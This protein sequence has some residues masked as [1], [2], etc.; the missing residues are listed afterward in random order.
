[1][2][3]AGVHR[4][5]LNDLPLLL[6][7]QAAT[8]PD[9]LSARL[10]T[11]FNALFHRSMLEEE[12]YLCFGYFV[13]GSPVGYLSC[14]SNTQQLLRSAFRRKMPQFITTLTRELLSNMRLWRLAARIAYSVATGR[15]EPASAVHAEFLSI[16]VLP[17]FRGRRDGTTGAHVSV[18][19]LLLERAL[20]ALGERGVRAVKACVT[21]DNAV[22]NGFYKKNAFVFQNRI[23][24]F[25]LAAYLYVRALDPA[26]GRP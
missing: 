6:E 16:G 9:T 23:H 22:A 15:G 2:T 7:I 5:T 12:E 4:L 19:S 18:A 10:G 17:S 26:L 24:R 20:A 3:R 25:G 14:T 1:M 21:P 13:D 8:L 11:R